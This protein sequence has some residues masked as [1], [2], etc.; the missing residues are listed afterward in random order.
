MGALL[1][2]A[3]FLLMIALQQVAYARVSVRNMKLFQQWVRTHVYG[4]GNVLSYT[5][6]WYYARGYVSGNPRYYWAVYV[7]I[8][9]DAAPSS[10][11]EKWYVHDFKAA[12]KDLSGS[13]SVYD[14]NPG[15]PLGCVNSWSGGVSASASMSPDGPTVNIGI[16]YT[17]SGNFYS[18]SVEPRGTYPKT[19]WVYKP[20]SIVYD[21]AWKAGS[22]AMYVAASSTAIKVENYVGATYYEDVKE[23]FL[24]YCWWSLKEIHGHEHVWYVT[25][26]PP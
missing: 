9:P 8:I 21:S 1:I 3:L 22:A 17:V 23:C 18:L 24:F 6:E 16:S 25:L 11:D 12:F 15:N 5:V 10:D 19:L 14:I 13:L 2:I 20:C 4:D 7:R 26:S